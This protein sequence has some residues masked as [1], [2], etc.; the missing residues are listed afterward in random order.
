MIT[1]ISIGRKH[2]AWIEPG[3]ERYQKRLRAPWDTRWELLPHSSY[4]GAQARQEESERI[5]S[6][7]DPTDIVILLDETGTSF[8]SPRLSQ[9][10]ADHFVR[11]SARIVCIIGGAYGVSDDLM[12][13]AQYIVSLSNLVFPHQLV[14][15]ILTEQIYR[16]QEIDHGTKYHHD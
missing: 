9:L 1:V 4:E 2:E 8:S 10:F 14:R 12:Q 13:R 11:S 3:L 16:C 5:L 15:L 7:L 6:R